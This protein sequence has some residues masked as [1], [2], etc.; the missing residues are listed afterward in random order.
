[1]LSGKQLACRWVK[2]ACE[3]HERDLSERHNK[4]LFFSTELADRALH[5]FSNLKLWKGREYQGKEFVLAPHFKFIVSSI[6]GWLWY[7]SELRRFKTAYVEMARKGAKSTFAGGVGAYMFLADHEHGAEI[8][9]AATKKDQAKI[10]W[11]TSAI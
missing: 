2:L 9:T 5:F 8:Y 4:D 7:E 10:V 3:R 6:F 1:V 11:Q